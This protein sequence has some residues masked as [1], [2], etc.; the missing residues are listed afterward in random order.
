MCPND[1]RCIS[2][3]IYWWLPDMYYFVKLVNKAQ[4]WNKKNSFIYSCYFAHS[5][6]LNKTNIERKQFHWL[7][8]S[9]NHIN[10]CLD[11]ACLPTVNTC[12]DASTGFDLLEYK[13]HLTQVISKFS[14]FWGFVVVWEFIYLKYGYQ[15][16]C[17]TLKDLNLK[18]EK[19]RSV[20]FSSK[21]II[22]INISV[23]IISCYRLLNG[24][25]KLK[26]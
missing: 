14:S 4:N 22:L 10:A 2:T 18:L 13:K 5:T 20:P 8:F 23:L 19:V 26:I 12:F 15:K 21:S 9:S 6:L 17:C 1:C 25:N 3:D 16:S 11:G 24:L 7:M